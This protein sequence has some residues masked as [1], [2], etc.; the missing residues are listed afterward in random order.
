MV[1]YI[2]TNVIIK[3]KIPH[4]KKMGGKWYR[5]FVLDRG[6]LPVARINAIT[7]QCEEVVNTRG[8]A[9]AA[10]NRLKYRRN[11]KEAV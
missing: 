9:Y 1:I 11:K 2:D 5:S 7:H 4:I 6:E 8:M 10:R 3:H